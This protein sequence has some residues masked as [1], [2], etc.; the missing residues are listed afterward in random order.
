MAADIYSWIKALHIIAVISWMAGLLYLP[1]LFVYHCRSEMGSQQSE[2]FKVMEDRLLKVIMGPAMI[3]SWAL[4]IILLVIIGQ[5][6]WSYEL[7]VYG[8][9]LLVV[10]LTASHIKLAGHAKSFA[11]DRNAKPEKYFRI[12]N[13]VPTVLMIGIV[14]LV[15]V[16]PF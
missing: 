9:L 10:A 15:T 13:E 12:I 11:R 6:D 8:K 4:G 7:W 1:R 2:T 16:K 14:I 3:A 5:A